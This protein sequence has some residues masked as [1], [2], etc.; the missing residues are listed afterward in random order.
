[1][2]VVIGV[3][4]PGMTD[5]KPTDDKPD[6]GKEQV[7]HVKNTM[8]QKY[9]SLDFSVKWD[10][11]TIRDHLKT[12]FA[13]G[14]LMEVLNFYQKLI[15]DE[16]SVKAKD[17]IEKKLSSIYSR[18]IQNK[19]AGE[20]LESLS[21]LHNRHLMDKSLINVYFDKIYILNLDRR[22]DRMENMERRLKQWNIYNWVRFS[23]VDGSLSPHWEEWKHYTKSKMTRVEKQKY[24]RKAIASCGSWAI[25]KSMYHLLRDAQNH[26]YNRIL[27]LQ[28]DVLFHKKFQDEFL[29]VPT[30]VPDNWKLLYLGGTQH[31]WNY[32]I[33]SSKFYYP[34]GTT[35]GAFAVGIHSSIY[36]ELITEILKFD[37]PVDSGAL[38]TLQQKYLYDSYVLSPNLIIADIRDSDLRQSRDLVNFGMRFKW[39]IKLYHLE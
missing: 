7:K 31:S 15:V 29:K 34:N 21:F 36:E 27:V 20:S 37:M 10:L 24:H 33:Q 28:D 17:I 25:L 19:M 4:N 5:D 23:A 18:F 32:I 26:K 3:G 1:M 13:V 11:G 8:L 35:D 39:D 16:K 38:R 9:E 6:E 22:P 12:D 14:D 2:S 30:W